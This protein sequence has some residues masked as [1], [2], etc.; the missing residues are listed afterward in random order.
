MS[1][2]PI[3]PS[4]LDEAMLQQLTA[5]L[6][7]QQL[8][9]LSGYFY[10]QATG[11]ATGTG[12][13]LAAAPGVAVGPSAAPAAAEKLTILYGSHT[14]NGKKIA[15]QAAE[16]AAARG[17][18]AEVR[19]MNDYSPRQLAQEQNLLV[20]VSTHGEGDP[21]VSAEELHQFLGGPRAPKLPNLK[22]SVL[23]LGDKSYLHF[24]QTGKDF[25]ERLA[26]LGGTRL[27]DRIDTD[28][29]YKPA[30]AHWIEASLNKLAASP[31][32]PATASSAAV[33]TEPA[34]QFSA[35]NP[36]PAKILETIQLN[37]RGSDKE[38]HHIE[39]DLAGSGLTYAPGD[40]LA[41]RP[42]NHD[43]LVEEVL[44][45]ARL[46]D[47]APVLL[48]S[49][50]LPLA[51]ALASRRELTVLT[52][53]V[54]ERYAALAPHTELHGLLADTSRLQP[55]LYGRD[56]ADLLLDFPTDQL[57]PQLLADTLRPLP[58]R[59][60]SIASSLLA[61]PDEV[62]LTV[63]A[64]RY[65]AHGRQ[66]QGVC[67]SLLADRVAVGDEVRVFVEHN[68]YFKLPK[69]T[70]TDIIMVGAGTGIAPFRA[71]VEER[72]ELG[73]SGRN[74]LL[75]GNPHFTTD[76]LYQA[77]WQQQLKRGGLAKLD[78]AFS[79]D[80]AEKVYVQDRLL[81]NSRDVFGWLENGAQFYVCGDKTRLGQAVQTALTQV[82]QKEA[83]ISPEEA[84]AYLKNLKK[85]RRYLEDVY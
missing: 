21:P 26:K 9:W 13:T 55:Y 82:V 43:P 63:G 81:E 38:T 25:D 18:K 15:E 1:S 6:S 39:L 60:Y 80:Q 33:V 40:A 22:F 45:A 67:S 14:G 50:N 4:H 29:A 11:A 10:G 52:R 37:G 76:F 65:Q 73:A 17:L 41:V 30:A 35:E 78:V 16:A 85:Q 3:L 70:S 23:A 8:V 28:V 68:E 74:W 2:L 53:D 36:W 59:A 66:K 54:L 61:H 71:F 44:R 69:D 34:T 42:L 46:S 57:T 79:R 51:A 24:C 12:A 5:S 27:L 19:D 75:F 47:S 58:T 84:A 31:A 72:A 48:G 7:P 62:H 32:A 77:E 49:E 83:G 56:V 20:V 64:V